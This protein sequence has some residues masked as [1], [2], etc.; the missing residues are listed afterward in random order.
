ME[1]IKPLLVVTALTLSVPALGETLYAPQ[2]CSSR[3]L[4][5]KVLNLGSQP[6]TYWI[7]KR[8]GGE[9]EEERHSLEPGQSQSFKGVEFLSEGA[10][11]STRSHDPHLKFYVSC[12]G[13]VPMNSRTSPRVEYPVNGDRPLELR[14]QNLSREPQTLEVRT[15]SRDGRT[16]QSFILDGGAFSESRSHLLQPDEK[17][18]TLLIT[19][20]G[21]INT[22]LFDDHSGQR[23]EPFQK[24]HLKVEIDPAATY[25]LAED[26]D[27]QESFSFALYDQELIAKARQALQQGRWKIVIGQIAA[28]SKPGPNRNF[29]TDDRAPWS[30]DV[31][32]VLGFADFAH[33]SCDGSPSMIEDHLPAWLG[34]GGGRIC[35]WGYHLKREL[36]HE[37]VRTGHP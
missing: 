31:T 15:F 34:P 22:V 18:S 27:G 1:L 4:E 29:S 28:A 3:L 36:S 7:L 20:Q 19:A 11:F 21:R 33:I 9:A 26:P 25:F 10:S 37:E 14:W 35:L 12:A 6:A 17:A 32:E 30:W 16:L 8:Q 13:L 2:V 5:L 24:P 23:I